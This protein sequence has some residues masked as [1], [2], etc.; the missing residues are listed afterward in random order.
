MCDGAVIGGFSINPQHPDEIAVVSVIDNLR[1]GAAS[2]AIQN[3]NLAMG[4]DELMGLTTGN[5]GDGA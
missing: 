3:I 2:Q 5:E 1:K 4:Y